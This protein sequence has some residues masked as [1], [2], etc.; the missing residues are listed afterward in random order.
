MKIIWQSQ[1]MQSEC[2]QCDGVPDS[3]AGDALF[4]TVAAACVCLSSGQMIDRRCDCW[5]ISMLHLF[6]NLHPTV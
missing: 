3:H 4:Q 2:L 1:R 6:T 5:Q